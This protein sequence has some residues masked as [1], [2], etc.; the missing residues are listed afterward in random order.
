MS[1]ALHTPRG[2]QAAEGERLVPL[3][4]HEGQAGGLRDRL[5]N[6]GGLKPTRNLEKQA[7]RECL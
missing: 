3:K 2:T 7:H 5:C 6:P 4:V 1:G